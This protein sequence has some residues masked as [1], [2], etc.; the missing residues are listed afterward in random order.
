MKIEHKNDNNRIKIQK[1]RN[2]ARIRTK[3]GR[4][5]KKGTNNKMNK[6]WHKN[7]T[8]ME[9]EVAEKLNKI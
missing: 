8:Q 9:L 6:R 7:R 5:S 2:V 1:N 3:S 4:K